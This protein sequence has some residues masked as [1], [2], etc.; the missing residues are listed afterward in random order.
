MY[1]M[2]VEDKSLYLTGFSLFLR[3]SIIERKISR[4]MISECGLAAR[5]SEN[6]DVIQ[7]IGAL[8]R[9]SEN[10]MVRGFEV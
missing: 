8:I 6:L 4:E 3:A 2:E 10:T 9:G 1:M 5:R 7:R